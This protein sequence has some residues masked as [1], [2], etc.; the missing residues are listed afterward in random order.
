MY[1]INTKNY[2]SGNLVV[3]DGGIDDGMIP[4]VSYNSG[5]VVPGN[6]NFIII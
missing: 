5:K 4:G 6:N 1:V 2:Y 3:T